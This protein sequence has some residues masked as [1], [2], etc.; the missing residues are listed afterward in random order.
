[1]DH[2][3][4]P[5]PWQP[6]VNPFSGPDAPLEVTELFGAEGWFQFQLAERVQAA[7]AAA[8]PFLPT[9]PADWGPL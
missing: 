8:R 3:L 6:V 2:P 1:M 4:Q 5:L 7:D 9:A